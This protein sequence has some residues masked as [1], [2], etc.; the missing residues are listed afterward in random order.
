MC[1]VRGG[2]LGLGTATCACSSVWAG[3]ARLHLAA[4]AAAGV[5]GTWRHTHAGTPPNSAHLQERGDTNPIQEFHLLAF[6]VTALPLHC[7]YSPVYQS[8]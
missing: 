3:P 1:A 5:A 8:V 6:S 2:I 4:A 7:L